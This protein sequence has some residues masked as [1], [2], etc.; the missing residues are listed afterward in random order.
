MRNI[1]KADR[2]PAI[3]SDIIVNRPFLVVIRLFVVWIAYLILGE[4]VS[5]AFVEDFISVLW[6]IG[7]LCTRNRVREGPIV[8]PTNGSSATT[9]ER[10]KEYNRGKR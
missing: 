5:N 9:S 8:K 10:Q 4:R 2:R 6:S 1:K 3:R 7:P